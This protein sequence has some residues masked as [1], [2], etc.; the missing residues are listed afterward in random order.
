MITGLY[1][2]LHRAQSLLQGGSMIVL[3]CGMGVYLTLRTRFFQVRGLTF[4][5]KNTV[6]SL[7]KKD[8]RP[9]SGGISPFQAVSTALAGT[10]G[11]GNIAGVATALTLGGAGALFWMWV[12]SF[13]GMMTKY[14][15][16]VLAVRYRE[17][18]AGGGWRGGPM[19]YIEK[20]LG[21]RWMAKL[22]AVLCAAGSF[23]IGNM[24]QGNAVSGAARA[25]FGIPI[26]LSGLITAFI[27]ALVIF[28]GVKRIATVAEITIPFISVAYIAF[29][30][31]AVTRG[32]DYLGGAVS[33]IFEQAFT[34]QSA[35]GGVAGYGLL[36]AL[37][38]GV[39][40][41]V[42][43]NE[44]GMGAASIA[45]AAADCK[46]PAHQGAWGIF[47]VFLDTNTVCTLTGLVLLTAG[48]GRLW[49]S[50]L[51]GV[52]MTTAA[53]VSV[54][55]QLGATFIAISVMIFAVAGMLGWCLYGEVSIGYLTG[56]SARM[57]LLY[58]M[59]FVLCVYVGAVSELRAVWELTDAL[60]ALMAIPNIAA[61]WLLRRQVILPKAFERRL[62]S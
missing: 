41:G 27:V 13:F 42:F 39:S 25:A 56:Q 62:R 36:T 53:F 20:G 33:L 50:G 61:I 58:R 18:D 49:S 40:R 29:C 2:I 46:S 7:L 14:A 37:R 32:S 22:F 12:S 51:D 11:V 52:E 24:T 48:G 43:T 28:G 26:W 45:H 38:Y 47:E 3:I 23:G 8:D 60:N 16:I 31:V 30:L 6:G 1:D 35:V 4:V 5:W 21:K 19:Y 55:G 59:L 54:F 15:E 34:L 10:M 57:I 17:R 9:A 44:A